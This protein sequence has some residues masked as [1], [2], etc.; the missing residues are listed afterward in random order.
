MFRFQLDFGFELKTH[1]NFP[2]SFDLLLAAFF[3]SAGAETLRADFA[4]D[5]KYLWNAPWRGDGY[6]LSWMKI[7]AAWLVFLAWVGVADWVNRDLEET[8]LKWQM[9]NPIVV[10][11]FMAAMF[12]SWLIPWFWLN[13][14]LLLGGA[15]APVATYVVYRNRRM[16]IHRQVLTKAH[17][18]FWFSDKMKNV[19]VKVSAEVADANTSG[20]PVKVYAR[21]GADATV[22]GARLLAARQWADF[23]RP[24]RSCTTACGRGPRRSCWTSRPRRSPSATWSTASG[25]PRSR[26]SGK[27]PTR[28]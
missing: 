3:V 14:F 25:C 20:V 17:L 26:W 1:E 10:G 6:Y 5:A 8:G 23:P 27:R 9:W 24:A 11:S 15:V 7:A 12:S 19:G 16:Q 28:P 13:I 21:G 2:F 4:E 18:R 22:D